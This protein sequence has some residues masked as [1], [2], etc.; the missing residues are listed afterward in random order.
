MNKK[1][2]SLI[3]PGMKF[4]FLVM[5]L[6]A[7][8]TAVAGEYYLC[9]G[10]AAVTLILYCY[11][12]ISRRK[13][14]KRV[15]SYIQ[16]TM[17][18]MDAA[19]RESILNI[20]LPMTIVKLGPN[21]VMWAND[22][23]M[24]MMGGKEHFFEQ[25]L[26]SLV[27][28]FSTQ[29]LLDGKTECPD[30]IKIGDRR[31]HAFGNLVR[32]SDNE[33]DGSDVTLL[34]TIFWN[35]VT[36]HLN[37]IDEYS[38]SRP[39]AAVILLDNYDEIIKNLSDNLKS[40]LLASIDDKITAWAEP[41]SGVL[42][43]LERD[44]YLL[45]FEYRYLQVMIDGKFSILDSVRG[46]A[47]PSGVAS[48]LSIGIG[49][50]GLSYRENLEYALLGIEMS[51]SRGGDQAVIKD[52]FNFTFHGGRSK[53]TERR[54][55]V[56]S[57]VMANSIS[58]LISQS[59]AVFI[60]GHK[61]ADLD[62]VGA[63]AGI[64]CICRKRGR[65]SYIVI[66]MNKN[67]A[68]SL[69]GKLVAV[70]EYEDCFISAEDAILL[71]DSMSLLVV[72][73]T[74]R[75]DQ[76]ESLS[77]LE[78]CNKVAVIDHHR[79]AADYIDSVTLNFHEPF[80]S[81]ASELVS[82]LMQYTVE[83]QDILRIEAEALLSGIVLDTKNF[84]VRTSGRT[85]DAAAF[86]RRAGADTVEVKKLFQND[87]YGTVSRYEIIQAARLYRS[88]IAVAVVDKAVDRT[89]AA[90][91]ADELLNI[92]GIM[93]SF[94]MFPDENSGRVIISARSIGD[95]NVQVVLEPLGGGGNA[96]TA[97][98]QVPGAD[99]KEVLTRLVESLDKY[100]DS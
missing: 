8:A 87:L 80:A 23:F 47:N 12:L 33:G 24:Q 19:S 48:T 22:R 18:D 37:M 71:A 75:P 27:P 32:S 96:A 17:T 78:S 11:F 61:E 4:Y 63:A 46:V 62:T 1:L 13:T 95:V 2:S 5:L 81:S 74:N 72:V 79:R 93:T 100:L 9:I 21:E 82:E 90:Q 29:W 43:K 26:N 65:K 38:S 70:P 86:L 49:H 94:V 99:V 77:L 83:Q 50:G 39:V 35:D 10:E 64:R 55:K 56:K 88:E 45:L 52:R 6:F 3:E 58:E 51:L 42:R 40:T 67:A 36:E 41:F 16:S 68:G 91:A 14:G 31:Y 57:R 53:E 69:L 44:R 84:S 97:G 7:A 73:D 76:V 59:S 15:I 98:A 30:E 85:F 20:P 25:K 92:S 89:I 60:M 34:A 66:D 54:T 28:G